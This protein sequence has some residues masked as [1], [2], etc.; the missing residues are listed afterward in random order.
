MASWRLLVG[1]DRRHQHRA[2]ACR[3]LVA[4]QASCCAQAI[5]LAMASIA[6]GRTGL[7]SPHPPALAE[8]KVATGA[9]RPGICTIDSGESSPRRYFRRHRHAQHGAVVLAPACRAGGAAPPAPAM[10]AR[11][12]RSGGVLQRSQHVVRR[13]VRRTTPWPRGFTP[14]RSASPLR[15]HDVPVG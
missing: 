8:A 7:H 5:L 12:P 11:I 10:I 4:E 6:A 15:V 14:K 9:R 2:G 13:A 1:H 3:L